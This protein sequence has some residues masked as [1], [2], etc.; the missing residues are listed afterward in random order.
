[1][2]HD[3]AAREWT[4]DRTSAVG[5]HDKVLDEPKANGWTVVDMRQDW[6]RTFAFE[7]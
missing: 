3:D 1:M 6:T 2:N 4:Y 7:K 5:R